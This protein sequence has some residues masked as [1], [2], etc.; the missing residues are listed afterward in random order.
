MNIAPNVTEHSG[1]ESFDGVLFARGVNAPHTYNAAAMAV[2]RAAIQLEAGPF[3]LARKRAMLAVC[4]YNVAER[5]ALPDADKVR[6]WSSALSMYEGIRHH[7]PHELARKILTQYNLCYDALTVALGV[8]EAA[9]VLKLTE[10]SVKD[11]TD[12]HLRHAWTMVAHQVSAIEYP[13]SRGE[14]MTG[15]APYIPEEDLPLDQ[16]RAKLTLIDSELKR[17]FP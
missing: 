14:D 7:V 17:R 5:Q 10:V 8:Y 3:A 4:N 12:N 13:I 2:A 9:R 11:M 6:T 16:L 15:L 1:R